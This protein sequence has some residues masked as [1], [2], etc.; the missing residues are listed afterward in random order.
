[1]KARAACVAVALTVAS[2][3]ACGGTADTPA[4]ATPTKR[5]DPVKNMLSAVDCSSGVKWGSTDANI[6]LAYRCEDNGDE[7]VF[8]FDSKGAEE[9][10]INRVSQLDLAVTQVAGPGWAV[11][12]GKDT[13]VA[14][15]VDYGGTIL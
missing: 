9:A 6:A 3:T 4:D 8:F 14:A 2:L 12:T 15:A 13:R 5:T 1:M 7:F 10:W 11:E